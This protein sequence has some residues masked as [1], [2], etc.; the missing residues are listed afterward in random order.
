MEEIINLITNNIM[1][2]CLTVILGGVLLFVFVIGIIL[3]LAVGLSY[4]LDYIPCEI[5]VYIETGVLLGIF[6][7][8]AYL[9][10]ANADKI[11][12]MMSNPLEGSD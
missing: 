1:R 5:L 3:L 7:L 4:V 12:K 10:F 9:L 2:G 6:M 8:L 11:K